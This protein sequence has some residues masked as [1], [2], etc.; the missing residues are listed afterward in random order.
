ME[1]NEK[2]V[3]EGIKMFDKKPIVVK[4]WRPDIE[5]DKQVV[6]KIHVWIRLINLDIKYWGQNA[7]TKIEG[8]IGNPLKADRATIQKERLQF[9]RILVEVTPNQIY[10]DKVMFEN[11]C[12]V[13][14]EH[15]VKYEWKLVYCKSCD[16]FGHG[17]KD[18][19]MKLRQRHENTT[20]DAS[21]EPDNRMNKMN[22]NVVEGSGE[23]QQSN[24]VEITNATKMGAIRKI[25]RGYKISSVRKLIT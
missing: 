4:P 1:N 24:E 13:I 17:I 20:S 23:K 3:E 9:A 16:N 10:P 11:E 15:E 5:L 14:I 21:R 19:R 25:S 22:T 8:I 12:G 18:C 2:V 6:D 7:L